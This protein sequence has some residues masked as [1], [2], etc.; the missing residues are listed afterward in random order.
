[1]RTVGLWIVAALHLVLAAPVL[2]Q[3]GASASAPVL[4]LRDGAQELARRGW[5]P[6]QADL[7]AL[8]ERTFDM[9]RI[10]RAVL[11]RHG[12]TA[13]ADQQSKLSRVLG[14]RMAQQMLRVRPA[15]DDG[16]AIVETRPAGP[17]QWLVMTRAEP[18]TSGEPV[19]LGWRVAGVGAQAR[20]VD[21]QRDGVSA[22]T[23]QRD[24]F[25]ATVGK[26]GLEGA[27]AEL[28]RRV[29]ARP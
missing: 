14:L 5:P 12:A 29:A 6:A 17:D 24:D 9:A 23:T 1:V 18:G 4:A 22:T 15:P 20:I 16:F 10:T 8:I 26:L 21:V 2:A 11:G 25:A 28:E 13:P 3:D 19:V 7:L 27:I